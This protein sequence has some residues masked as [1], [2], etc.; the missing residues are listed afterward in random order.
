MN[1]IIGIISLVLVSF[2]VFFAYNHSLKQPTIIPHSTPQQ[3]TPP[4]RQ[5]MGGTLPFPLS[6][7][8]GFHIGL[9]AD[10]LGTARDLEL[11]PEGTLLVSDPNSNTVTA[12]RDTDG[13]GQA[14]IKKIII[15]GRNIVHGVAFHNGQ[16]FVAEKNSIELYSWNESLMQALYSKTVVTFPGST[17]HVNRTLVFAPGNKMYINLGSTCNVCIEKNAEEG[18]I[19]VANADGSDLHI[20]A[21]GQRNAPFL[22]INPITHQLWATGMGRDYLGDTIPPDEINII[23]EGKDYGWPICY[24][25]KIHDTSFDKKVYISDPCRTTI[26][27]IYQIA[28][29]S[30]PLG[31]A[32]VPST[33]NTSWTND[34]VVAYHG[35]W[36]RS[37]PIGYKVV[38]M[39]V[40]GDSIEGE[41]DLVTGFL[42]DSV[43]RG[44]PVDLIF[45]TFG[46]LY[47]SDD[48]NGNIYIVSHY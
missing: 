15:N 35:S 21:K 1:K 11:T 17:D 42:K 20:F 19:L 4:T 45:D 38:H 13:D 14:D 16:L 40:R 29:H 26:P 24:G 30:A 8:D 28:A 48:K 10:R 2:A 3:T 12:L 5:A 7:P 43:T 37:T 39:R 6:V 9:F 23:E 25:D 31:L 32:F 47:I 18:T 36:N 22:A 34:L 27:P 44:R 41:E 33:F 46:N